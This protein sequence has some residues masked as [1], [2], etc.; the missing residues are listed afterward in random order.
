M[1]NVE[2]YLEALKKIQSVCPTSFVIFGTLLG[3]IRNNAFISWDGDMDLG[4][5]FEDW[6]EEMAPLLAKEGFDI[7]ANV[8]WYNPKYYPLIDNNSINKRALVQMT[9]LDK[10][11]RICLE[12]LSKGINN[13]RYSCANGSYGAFH[14]PENLIDKRIK[15]S[16]YDT[17]INIPE[18]SESFLE[19]MYG[20]DWKIPKKKYY[21]TEEHK[22]NSKRFKIYYP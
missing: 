19:F 9:Y 12:V 20:K 11:V 10:S 2:L 6:Q 18:K 4:I 8:F 22:E 16:F 17:I 3:A 5:M 7:I 13:E 15:K 1:L 14:C 21:D